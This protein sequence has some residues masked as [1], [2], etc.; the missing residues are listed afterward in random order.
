MANLPHGILDDNDDDFGM[1]FSMTCNSD[2]VIVGYSMEEQRAMN[3]VWREKERERQA[4]LDRV[5]RL[6]IAA[7]QT[8]S[9]VVYLDVSE[10][11]GWWHLTIRDENGYAPVTFQMMR[12]LSEAFGTDE[13][14]LYTDNDGCSSDPGTDF[15]VVRIKAK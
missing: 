1:T 13:L 2:G 4:E 3:R 5:K 14:N 8:F 9:E 15:M 6:G 12:A 10:Q 7:L 11:D